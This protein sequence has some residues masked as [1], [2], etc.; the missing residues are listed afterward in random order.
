MGDTEIIKLLDDFKNNLI[1]LAVS[2]TA[3]DT[4]NFKIYEKQENL[5]NEVFN[6]QA[7][8]HINYYKNFENLEQMRYFIGEI[9]NIC[10]TF[11][12]KIIFVIF[13]EYFF[14]RNIL[15]EQAFSGLCIIFKELAE[16]I[17]YAHIFFFVNIL[18][19]EQNI[20]FEE[21]EKYSGN[22]RISDFYFE[23]TIA[24]MKYDKLSKF[25]SNTTFIIYKG[26]AIMKYLKSSYADELDVNNFKF[27]FGN[28]IIIKDLELTKKISNLID[29]F[30]CMDLTVRPYYELIINND[31]SFSSDTYEIDRINNLKSI[32]K[33]Y[34]PLF[35]KKS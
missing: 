19:Q 6:Y 15:N 7:S 23:T 16:K 8:S 9:T 26:E 22:F 30:I 20:N 24:K 17:P 21:M 13:N 35:K 2:K 27:G 12:N 11:K 32:L 29:I 28:L 18:F 10:Y 25:Y 31:F 34:N 33:K 4:I 14:G 3:N 1:L 5:D